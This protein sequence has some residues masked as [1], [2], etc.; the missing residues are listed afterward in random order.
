MYFVFHF[1]RG[2]NDSDKMKDCLQEY[3]VTAAGNYCGHKTL[4]KSSTKGFFGI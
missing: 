1:C 2:A 3:S 4:S